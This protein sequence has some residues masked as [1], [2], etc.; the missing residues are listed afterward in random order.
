MATN[1]NHEHFR[2]RALSHALEQW[3]LSTGAL[4][5]LD[6]DPLPHQLYLV[7]RVLSSGNLN[8]LIADDVGLGKT[9]EVGLLILA[10]K[11]RGLKRFLLVVPAGLTPQWKEELSERFGLD[12]FLI[13]GNDFKAEKS[14]DWQ[15]CDEVIA[16]MDRLKAEQHLEILLQTETWDLIIFDEAH[17]LTRSQYGEKFSPSERFQLAAKLRP[18]TNAM[19]L[20]T[21]TPHQGKQDRFT[22]LLEL[23]RPAEQK[24]IRRLHLEPEFLRNVI[25]RNRK[26]D[27]TD[28]EGKFVFQ[29]KVTRTIAVPTTD[30]EREF[31]QHLKHYLLEGYNAGR[32]GG[33]LGRAIGF[34]MTIYRKLAASSLFAIL[35]ALE[36]RRNRLLQESTMDFGENTEHDE[37]DARFQGEH[38]ESKAQQIAPVKAFFDDELSKLDKLITVGRELLPNDSK[39]RLFMETLLKSVLAKDQDR[40]V[41]I[42]SEYKTTQDYLEKAL[43]AQF[44]T[45]KVQTIHGSK[46][47][48]ERRTAMKIFEEQGQFLISTEAGGEGLN[49]QR[50]CHTMINFDLPWNPM[51][52]VQRVGRLYRYGQKKRVIVFNMQSPQSLDDEIL[53]MMYERLYAVAKDMVAVGEEYQQ[54]QLEDDILGELCEALDIEE[55]L[56]DA[57]QHDIHRSQERID[58]ALRKAKEAAA[59]QRD[60]LKHASRYD[61]TLDSDEL[62]LTPH[63]LKAFAEGMF[64]ALEYQFE[65]IDKGR[66]WLLNLPP[67]LAKRLSIKP[68]VRVTTE[69][70]VKTLKPEAHL[71][72]GQ[73]PLFKHLLSAARDNNFGGLVASIAGL[74]N[75]A[76]INALLR[77]QNERG[78]L[79]RQEY[80]ALCVLDDGT[81]QINP[82]EFKAWL[83]EPKEGI[84]TLHQQS[85]LLLASAKR[86]LET[87]LK[88]LSQGDLYPSGSWIFSAAWVNDSV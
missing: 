9:I 65:L 84:P 82:P 31:D 53:N 43:I 38:E 12:D 25:I 6:I 18:K 16:S 20:L 22:A 79:M 74:P 28:L 14:K 83:L 56:E 17:R 13:Y 45:E 5:T 39:L 15:R 55:I 57:L 70:E 7:N 4:E 19:L 40:H 85:E 42:F 52:L 73:S 48:N 64:N 11:R 41:L 81:V 34:V 63:H 76:V 66:S 37:A 75:H 80:A 87:R 49:L 24:A 26:A 88:N 86:T 44:G 62:R 35:T 23:L 68:K 32:E 58:E 36:K 21:G 30:L 61:P 33:N 51:R 8:W 69:R 50:R 59:L 78:I 29:G 77:W 60:L 46:T 2:L 72:D 3:N 47:I 67:E 71:L 27:V 54:E 1:D 10:L